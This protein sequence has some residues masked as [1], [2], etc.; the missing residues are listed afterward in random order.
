MNHIFPLQV[1]FLFGTLWYFFFKMATLSIAPN[2]HHWTQ[3]HQKSSEK[4][5]LVDLFCL[6]AMVSSHKTVARILEI[7]RFHSQAERKDA[8]HDIHRLTLHHGPNS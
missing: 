7:F 3:R 4:Y 6:K 1:G 2:L 8:I 5:K